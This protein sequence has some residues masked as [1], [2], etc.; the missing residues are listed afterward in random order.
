MA[1][2]PAYRLRQ[3]LSADV[4]F[5]A[6]VVIAAD[7]RRPTDFDEAA[8]RTG[9]A[10][11]TASQ[12]GDPE[13]STSVIEVDGEAVGRLRIA[14][15]AESIELCG[16]QLLPRVQGRG[17]GTAII[18]SLQSEATGAGLPLDI[19]VEKDNPNARRLYER[20][21]CR[22]IGETDREYRLRWDPTTQ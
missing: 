15:N 20:L 4:D 16:I 13:I 2:N 10:D 7:D 12:L 22:Q 8:W 14:R 11:W 17:I 1:P 18:E 19:G 9:F 21:G 3:A 5:L 6:D